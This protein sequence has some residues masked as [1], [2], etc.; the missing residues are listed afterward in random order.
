MNVFPSGIEGI[1]RRFPAV[2]EFQIEVFK[3]GELD[4]VRVAVELR[5]GEPAPI[6]EALR[7]ALG[8]RIPVVPAP[9]GSLP[10]WELKA[11]RLARGLAGPPPTTASA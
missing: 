9:P 11:R 6:Q 3:E 2:D 1:V 10:R 5:E 4:E 8:I 7:Q